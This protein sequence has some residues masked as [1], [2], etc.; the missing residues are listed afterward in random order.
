[1]AHVKYW[2][3]EPKGPGSNPTHA[4]IVFKCENLSCC[5]SKLNSEKLKFNVKNVKKDFFL[6]FVAAASEPLFHSC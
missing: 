1:M 2:A 6:L 3:G 4:F 5:Y